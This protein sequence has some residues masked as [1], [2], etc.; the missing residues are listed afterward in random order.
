LKWKLA[1][2]AVG[3][4]RLRANDLDDRESEAGA[5]Q[6]LKGALMLMSIALLTNVGGGIGI[7][8]KPPSTIAAIC[9]CVVAIAA[10]YVSYL[11]QWTTVPDLLRSVPSSTSVMVRRLTLVEAIVAAITGLVPWALIAQ[12]VPAQLV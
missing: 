10:G 6:S 2:R 7:F 4:S 1:A 9:G 5:S 8:L 3:A 12:I 11:T